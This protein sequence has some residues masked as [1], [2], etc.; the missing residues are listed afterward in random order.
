MLPILESVSDNGDGTCTAWWGYQNNNSFAVTLPVGSNNRFTPAPENRS[1]LTT[2][3]S[4]RIVNAFNVVFSSSPLVWSLD[5]GTATAN[6]TGTCASYQITGRIFEDANYSGGPGTGFGG[7]GVGLAN[8]QVEVYNSGNVLIN[9]TSTDA[10][11]NYTFT[12]PG[13]SN[14]VV[15][16]V[17][18]SIGDG[19]T[20][21][22]AGFN[23]GFSS[24]VAEQT[25][26]YNGVSGNGGAGALGGNNAQ[27]SDL[28][29]GAGA[30]PGD[31]NVAVTVG[32]AS[33]TG[34]DFGFAYNLIVNTQDSGQGSLR[35][36][37]LNAN[38]V[39]GPASSQFNIPTTDPNYNSIMA[40]AFVIRPT[41]ALPGL[42]DNATAIDGTT[43]E[44][45]Q[46]DL[47]S[48]LPDVVI[49]GVSAGANVNG[50]TI[51]SN[52]N[53]IRRLDVRNF[54]QNNG[55]GLVVDGGDGNTL[56]ENYL[57]LNTNNSGNIGAIQFYNSTDTN[58]ISGNTITGNFSDG[59]IIITGSGN[60]VTNNISTA[61]GQDGFVL[62]GTSMTF[63]GN[64]A[65]A[66]APT[67]PIG[68][69]IEFYTGLTNS[70]IADNVSSG[71][72][73]EGG[74][75]LIG[76]VSSNNTIGPDNIITGNAGPGISSPLVGSVN[77]RFTENQISANNGL[78]IDLGVTGVT[79]NDPVPPGGDSD[80]G[81][82]GLM[83]FPVLY[84]AVIS[85]GDITITGEGRPGADI[86]FFLSDSDSSGYGEGQ[87]LIG[88][89]T[90]T[91]GPPGTTDPTAQQ[92]SFTF[93]AGSVVVGN[94]VTATAT[95][96]SNNTSEFAQNI[97]VN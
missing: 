16:V 77:N 48:G 37:I 58:T 1:Q 66:N 50:L 52:S 5:G 87:T 3:S 73:G 94:R 19:D 82:N 11:G 75:C 27:A 61:N 80:N 4:G 43:Q 36:F 97:I 30:G 53:I 8:V 24:A 64:T 46:G 63:T 40:N 54:N 65:Q 84:N 22:A 67:N 68:C 29:V 2:F 74:I 81:S 70:V 92:F 83:N 17:S 89:D 12:V 45:N 86:E 55:T 59:L 62:G 25:Y 95:D 72:G 34:V 33:V 31:T 32:N 21:P 69:G 56:A 6:P 96:S 71:N 13:G 18:A 90:I 26:E 57:T 42:T 38:A 14:Y 49:D 35:Q 10:S 7:G 88:S 39:A 28:S 60:Q 44:A 79:P 93:P 9:S 15:R 51:Y 23:G 20:P 85:G 91:S 76:V 47:R 41:S 78:G